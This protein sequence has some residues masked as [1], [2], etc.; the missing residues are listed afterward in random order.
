MFNNEYDDEQLAV[1]ENYRDKIPQKYQSVLFSL[2]VDANTMNELCSDVYNEVIPFHVAKAY[3]EHNITFDV[4]H[5]IKS[6]FKYLW[7]IEKG[8][9]IKSKKARKN[10]KEVEQVLNSCIEE[11]ERIKDRL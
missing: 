5:K 1:I 6:V 3:I 4:F 11:I 2:K 9:K 10:K 8:T 7:E